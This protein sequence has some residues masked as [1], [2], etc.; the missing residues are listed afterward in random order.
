MLVPNTMGH[1]TLT[2]TQLYSH[3]IEIH[4][5]TCFSIR[6]TEIKDI[7]SEKV[8]GW[9]SSKAQFQAEWQQHSLGKS[10]SEK[11]L[12]LHITGFRRV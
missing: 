10:N 4:Q 7:R 5:G 2:V 1:K 6:N 9:E 11:Y 8:T 3:P 12:I